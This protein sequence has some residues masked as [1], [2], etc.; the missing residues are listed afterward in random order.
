MS[1]DP[2]LKHSRIAVNLAVDPAFKAG[3][4]GMP[5]GLTPLTPVADDAV[6]ASLVYRLLIQVATPKGIKVSVSSRLWPALPG[7]VGTVTGVIDKWDNRAG[8]TLRVTRTEPDGST[9]WDLEDVH[10]LLL[11]KM[12]FKFVKGPRGEAL[13]LRGAAR[14]SKEEDGRR[15]SRARRC[16]GAGLQPTAG[17]C[18]GGVV[19]NSRAALSGRGCAPPLVSR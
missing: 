15:F 10:I 5:A 14:G 13:M 6:A 4:A 12:D 11:P 9:C 19:V 17:Q 2:P 18:A 1:F 7:L 3:G 16:T 8:E